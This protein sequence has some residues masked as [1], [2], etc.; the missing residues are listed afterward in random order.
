[1]IRHNANTREPPVAC[2][3]VEAHGVSGI[4]L[5]PRRIW[6]SESDILNDR[7]D[8]RNSRTVAD[9]GKWLRTF[10]VAGTMLGIWIF[11]VVALWAAS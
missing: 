3:R 4:G 10:V 8:D 9:D 11:G 2:L 7:I 5:V 6:E 1:M